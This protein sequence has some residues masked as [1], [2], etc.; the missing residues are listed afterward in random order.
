M[1]PVM[2]DYSTSLPRLN[3]C[4]LPSGSV[5][6]N[7]NAPPSGLVWEAC[8]QAK[9][10]RSP[11]DSLQVGVKKICVDICVCQLPSSCVFCVLVR[12][13]HSTGACSSFS[14]IHTEHVT[15]LVWE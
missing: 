7:A 5:H 4:A 2:A 9:H 10:K 8:Y 13:A 1:H 6:L 3:K 12:F 11:E 14:T 15:S